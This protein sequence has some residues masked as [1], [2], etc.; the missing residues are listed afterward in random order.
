MKSA[1]R[2]CATRTSSA[3]RNSLEVRVRRGLLLAMAAGLLSGC[4]TSRAPSLAPSQIDRT[5]LPSPSALRQADALAHFGGALTVPE[6][7]R[8]SNDRIA[9]HLKASALLD[10][11]NA[12]VVLAA[13]AAL[14]KNRTSDARSI[15]ERGIEAHPEDARIHAALGMTLHI[16]G[17]DRAAAREFG[18]LIRS[19]PDDADGYVRLASLRLAQQRFADAADVVAEGVRRPGHNAGLWQYADD[20][21]RFL[22]ESAQPKPALRVLAALRAGQPDTPLWMLLAASA[23]GALGRQRAAEALIAGARQ[24]APKD[25]DVIFEAGVAYTVLA[26][27]NK[28]D[29]C[30]TAA[31]QC[32]PPREDFFARRAQLYFTAGDATNGLRLLQDGIR[33]MPDNLEL[34]YYQGQLLNALRQPAAA[35]KVFA[36]LEPRV[37]ASLQHGTLAREFFFAY[38]VA[39]EQLGRNAEA[40]QRFE[41]AV[42]LNPDFAEALNYL[43]Y[44]WADK[45]VHLDRAAEYVQRALAEEPDNAAYLDTLG[46][47]QYRLGD[48]AAAAATLRQA[49]A[50]QGDDAI[51]LEHLGDVLDKLGDGGAVGAWKKSYQLGSDNPAALELKLR[52]KGVKVEKL[53]PTPPATVK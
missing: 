27:T 6:G 13:A 10:P 47:V 39:L 14:S 8:D 44:I 36:G 26:L 11:G 38:G 5:L 22:L 12:D 7:A 34:P 2:R 3:N 48:Y 4:A 51:M 15:L 43:A 1:A 50:L 9:A 45:G 16:V 49:V 33:R 18:W 41:A 32:E 19:R 30:F 28:A 46:W 35:A 31:L 20:L 21:V 29:A 17:Q 40:E 53:R 23:E 25:P 42:R 52:A 37:V 24:R